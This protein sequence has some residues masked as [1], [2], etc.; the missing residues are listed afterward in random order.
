YTRSGRI[1]IGCRRRGAMFRIEVWDTGVGIP[2]DKILE[3]FREFHQLDN[4]ARNSERG[5][6]LG[7]AIVDRLA[8]LL[9][10][11]LQ[12]RSWSGRGSCGAE[13]RAGAGAAAAARL[14]QKDA[15][16]AARGCVAVLEDEPIVRGAL[17]AVPEDWV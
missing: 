13:F 2:E 8:R 12:V 7:L 10:H 1:L 3:I 9:Q 16:S 4:D 11:R 5:T 17:R 6:G 14:D 15:P